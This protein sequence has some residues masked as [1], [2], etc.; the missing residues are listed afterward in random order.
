[1]P[2]RFR[3]SHCF[4]PLTIG[5]RKAG[6]AI[7][8]PRCLDKE[9]VPKESDPAL[10]GFH[11]RKNPEALEPLAESDCAE[12]LLSATAAFP[13][14]N[15]PLAGPAAFP[16]ENPPLSP[17]NVA[18]K[19]ASNDLG[20]S[21]SPKSGTFLARCPICHVHIKFSD[22]ALGDSITCPRCQN[23]FT[24]APED[25]PA[26]AGPSTFHPLRSE[27]APQR[28]AQPQKIGAIELGAIT[29]ELGDSAAETLPSFRSALVNP[30]G[31]LALFCGGIGLASASVEIMTWATFPL[32]LVGMPLAVIG[33]LKA[34]ERPGRLLPAAGGVVCLSVA[35]LGFFWPTLLGPVWAN[36]RHLVPVDSHHQY[37]V[38]SDPKKR[39]PEK[40]LK[41]PE[42][43]WVDISEG[44]IK[45]GPAQ[46]NIHK[47]V[48]APVELSGPGK[49]KLAGEKFL[50]IHV[51]VLNVGKV[52]MEY[53]SWSADKSLVLEDNRGK[54]H[55]L[56]SFPPG[57]KVRGSIARAY[58]LPWQQPQ[59][60]VL[61]FPPPEKEVEHFRLTLPGAAVGGPDAFRFKILAA[62]IS[63]GPILDPGVSPVDP[64]AN[65]KK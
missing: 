63:D 50:Q 53:H 27:S 55:S 26:A 31:V 61:V 17:P 24:A 11:L 30:W 10:A 52:P 56:V 25:A 36:S 46:V 12:F 48:L 29:G 5:T 35:V 64:K 58:V 60:D 16:G 9:V 28:N 44:G 8:C 57:V 6:S 51:R 54:K 3:C 38:P 40:L 42:A 43:T 47:A 33:F 22:A 15:P 39:E 23:Q 14:A 4:Q 37:V 2:I 13:E 20:P 62:A 7:H 34:E 32:C 41:K 21:G 65:S 1:M 18:A 45:Q 49:E 59:Y 19:P